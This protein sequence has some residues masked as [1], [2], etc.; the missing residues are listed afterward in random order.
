MNRDIKFR[1]L[2]EGE[3][4]TEEEIKIDG[5]MYIEYTHNKGLVVMCYVDDGY[6]G[7]YDELS[8]S[9]Y[10][11]TNQTDI[12]NKDIYDK[13]IVK[14]TFENSAWD[15]PVVYHEVVRFHNGMWMAGDKPLYR[16]EYAP[17]TVEVVGN[18]FENADLVKK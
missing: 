15:E 4:W 6:A 2:I 17:Y 8:E 14:L 1:F 11:F 16:D 12:N 3:L 18:V 5:D 13:D 9:C 7:R 10:Q